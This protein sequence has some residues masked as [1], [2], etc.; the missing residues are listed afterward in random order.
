MKKPTNVEMFNSLCGDVN[1]KLM[2]ERI[3]HDVDPSDC[4][5][6][7]RIQKNPDGGK[8]IKYYFSK[9]SKAEIVYQLEECKNFILNST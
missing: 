5:I 3:G 1:A 8:D 6:V 9:T 2:V 4:V 7:L